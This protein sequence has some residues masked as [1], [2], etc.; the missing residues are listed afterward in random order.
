MRRLARH[1]R[2]NG[3]L[4]FVPTMGFLHEGH[5]SLVR[6]ARRA[7]DSVV[8]SVFVNPAQFG[9]GEDL[10]RY[11]RDASR[12]ARLLRREGADVT[13]CPAAADVYPAGYSTRVEVDGL[14]EGL[15][16][17]YRPG[18]FRGVTT[19]VAKLLNIV[20][21]DVAVFGQK[22]AQQALVIRRMVRDLD[23]DTRVLVCPTV[24][25]RDGLALSSRNSLL[26]PRQRRQ[27]PVLY[28][29]LLLARRLVAGG[30]RSAA[31]IKR[32]MRDLIRRESDARV[33]YIEM[34]GTGDL[35]PVRSVEGRV[36]VAVAA[37]F[38]RTRLIDNVVVRG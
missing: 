23:F 13:F 27:A 28:R 20:G 4:A 7:C 25:E 10:E 8:V 33:Q 17:R 11:P 1:L 2:R 16:G 26:G 9:P 31:T 21:P 3:S 14:T 36:L 34:V 37:W 24:R 38:G 19:V 32:R 5:L 12:D 35:K 15:C 29:S 30:Q 18:H 22:D 6:R